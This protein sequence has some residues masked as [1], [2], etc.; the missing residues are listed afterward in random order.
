MHKWLL[1]LVVK[2]WLPNLVLYQ[3][4]EPVLV[5]VSWTLRTRGNLNQNAKLVIQTNSFEN[6]ICKLSA[7]FFGLNMLRIKFKM[8]PMMAKYKNLP[9]EHLQCFYTPHFNE[10]ERGYT[11]SPCPSVP[12]SVLLWRVVSDL[13]LQQYS[14]DPFHIYTSYQAV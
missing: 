11:V 14:S 9:P 7:I 12:P 13:Y 8:L 5:I 6:A 1:K 2:F 10:V 3:T 4:A